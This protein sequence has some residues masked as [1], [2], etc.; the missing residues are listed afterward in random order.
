MNIFD[1]RHVVV[2]ALTDGK[3]Y[4]GFEEI[5]WALDHLKNIGDRVG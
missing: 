1:F 5:M 3:S 4:R 2:H